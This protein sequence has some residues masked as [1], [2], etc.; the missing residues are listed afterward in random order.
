MP[1]DD[2]QT[3]EK[4]EDTV[5]KERIVTNTTQE[6]D[7]ANSSAIVKDNFKSSGMN[8]FARQSKMDNSL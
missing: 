4:K 5:E 8:Y 2:I 7:K 6:R 3:L 1:S